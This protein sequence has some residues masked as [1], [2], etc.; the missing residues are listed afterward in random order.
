[1]SKKLDKAELIKRLN[2][3]L[4]D[5]LW[6]HEWPQYREKYGMPFTIG[7]M[8]NF[9]SREEGPKNSVLGDKVYYNKADFITWLRQFIEKGGAESLPL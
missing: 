6:R 9:D 8:A 3:K 4:P 2:S 7:M 5:I 1:M